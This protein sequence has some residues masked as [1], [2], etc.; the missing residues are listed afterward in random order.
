MTSNPALTPTACYLCGQPAQIEPGRNSYLVTCEHCGV[1]YEID[2]TVW[3][4]PLENRA[5]LLAWI[6]KEQAG[7]H[8]WPYVTKEELDREGGQRRSAQA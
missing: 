2:L 5:G 8:K 3:T 1:R 6:R 4:T 7:G